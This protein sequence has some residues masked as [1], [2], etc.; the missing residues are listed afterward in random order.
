MESRR[1]FSWVKH[2]NFQYHLRGKTAVADHF[3]ELETEKE[4]DTFLCSPHPVTVEKQPIHFYE[5]ANTNL[6]FPL[7]QSGGFTEIICVKPPEM[8]TFKDSA[9]QFHFCCGSGSRSA[10]FTNLGSKFFWSSM[11]IPV[12]QADHESKIACL[13]KGHF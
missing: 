4:N 11:E 13:Q 2:I 5:G 1:V 6:H 7:L 3:H 9:D 10:P 12:S 8:T